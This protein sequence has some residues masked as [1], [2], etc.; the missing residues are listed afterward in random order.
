[1]NKKCTKCTND[2]IWTDYTNKNMCKT[3]F[4]E[5]IERR[6]RK[7]LRVNKLINIKKEYYLIEDENKKYKITKYF[8]KKIFEDRI[9][10]TKN[11]NA[12]QIISKTMDDDAQN[13]LD[14]FLQTNIYASDEINLLSVIADE[15]AKTIAKILKFD[16]KITPKKH[17]ELTKKDPQLLFS[18]QKSKKFIDSR[19]N[20]S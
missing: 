5:Q 11:K 1:M 19:K 2:A 17:L 3:H 7:H 4:L 14:Y 13:L 8:L 10:I 15:E 18:M 20:N 6:I 9:K 16:I 12:P